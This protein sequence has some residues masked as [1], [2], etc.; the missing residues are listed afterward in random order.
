MATSD[1]HLDHKERTLIYWWRKERLR[2]R[3]IGRRLRRSH[4]SI[5]RELRRN[6]WCG[7]PYFPRGA[8]LLSTDRVQRRAKR[9]RVQSTQVR[10]SVP[11][12]LHIGWTPELIAGRL[13]QQ[14]EL[15]TVC[16][17]SIDQYMDCRAHHLIGSLPRH[18][19]KRRPKR[20]YRQTGERIKH[21]PGLEQRPKAGGK[22]RACGHGEA[23]MIV[24]GDRT[25]GLNVLVERKS[26]LTHSS[27]LKNKTAAAT[28]HVLRRRL[29]A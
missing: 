10:E 4:P 13:K 1:R 11:Q 15:P 5:S 7:N 18:Q 14:G 21:R 2:L 29:N 17:E 22:R 27:C 6:R 19:H 16:H 26:R 9:E 8:Q 24:A 25:H 23:D 12:N 28:K 20:P 3:E